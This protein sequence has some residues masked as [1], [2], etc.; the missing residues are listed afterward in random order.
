MFA[1]GIA[2]DA[3]GNARGGVRFPDVA[4]GRALHIASALDVEVFPGL[5]GLI[6]LWFDLACAPAPGSD[7]VGPRFS[8]HRAY[9]RSV[10]RQARRLRY[11]GYLLP[12][13]TREMISAARASDVGRPGY[14]DQSHH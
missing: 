10:T 9:V 4:N 3:N 13:D 5:P 11:Q 2:R 6:G 14:C 12:R 7:S 1:T 8:S